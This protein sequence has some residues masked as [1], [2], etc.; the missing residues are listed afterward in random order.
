MLFA[1]KIRVMTRN[2][3]A[4][5]ADFPILDRRVGDH[6][7]VY[8][9]NAA[10]TQTPKQVYETSEAFYEGY[11]ANVH[12]G[13]HTL[14]HEA[15]TA[16][17]EAH[18]RLAEFVGASGG[19]EE[20]IF[21]KNATEGINLVAYGLGVNELGPGDEIVTT[22]ME[23]HASLVTWQQVAKKTGA[24][25]R[26]IDVTADGR[27]DMDHAAELIGPDTALVS[28]V[29]VSNVLGTINPVSELADLA[30]EHD[31]YIF[32]DGAQSAPNRPIDVEAMDADFF[33]FSGHKMAGPTGIGGLYGKRAL[34]EEMEP[35]LFG[36]EM[37][38][39]VTFTDSSW[40]GLP[41][42]FEAGTPPIAEG[43]ALAAAVD[44]L[45]AI[46]M[47]AIRDHENELVQYALERLAERN[48]VETYGPPVGVERTGVVAFNVDGIHGHDLSSL[49]DQRGIA[50]RSGDH[51]TQPLHDRLDIPGSARA[52]FYIYNTIEEVDRLLAAIDSAPAELDDY[53]SGRYHE[54]IHEHYERPRNRGGLS[55]PTFTKHSEETSC[56]DDGEFHVALDP[57]GTIDRLAFESESCAVSSSVASIL[58]EHLTGEPIT[59]AAELDGVVVDLLDGEFPDLRHDCV[60][61]PEE[62]IREGA[63]EYLESPPALERSPN[64]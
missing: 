19:R 60:V 27:L 37:I 9:D 4:S 31:A 54:S 63:R 56:G 29:H 59:A 49:F 38:R 46:G 48:D 62:V 5:R 40:N 17:E 24:D 26:Y 7:L 3:S 44:Y 64:R 53:L 33:T 12:R 30:H 55:D 32:V 11:N 20:M 22:E 52:S 1:S 39:N 43:I 61:G 6:R 21:T 42:K 45:E 25:V 50:I 18:D 36:G 8:L 28:V 14:S 13:I 41:W 23:H 34:L 47:D 58:S 2:P 16:Y 51:C 15:S 57:D 35:F 10:T